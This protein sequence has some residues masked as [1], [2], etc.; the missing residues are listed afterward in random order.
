MTDNMATAGSSRSR[1]RESMPMG[2][3][4][5]RKKVCNPAKYK[6]EIYHNP[7]ARAYPGWENESQPWLANIAM[8]YVGFLHFDRLWPESSHEHYCKSK[9]A[10]YNQIQDLETKSRFLTILRKI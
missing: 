6:W 9:D 3:G 5:W 4:A 7:A 1:R 10:K 2:D 8:K